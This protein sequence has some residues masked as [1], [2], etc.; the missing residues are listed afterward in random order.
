MAFAA[1]GANVTEIAQ[2][3]PAASDVPHVVV[4]L[5][6]VLSASAGAEA[7]TSVALPVLLTVTLCVADVAPRFTEPNVSDDEES[8]VCG[9]FCVVPPPPPLVFEVEPLHP[10]RASAANRKDKSE[11][12][13][14]RRLITV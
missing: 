6:L 13:D 2:V 11:N 1:V 10:E 8:D 14:R 7:K 3:A 12:G 9:P 5:K 4:M